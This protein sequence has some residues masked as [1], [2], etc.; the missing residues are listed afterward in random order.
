MFESFIIT[1]RESLEA[2]LIIGIV[3]AFLKNNKK[4]SLYKLIL[5]S[6]AAA[7]GASLLFAYLFSL[8]EGGFSGLNEELFEGITML[9]AGSLLTYMIVWLYKQKNYG[10]ELKSKLSQHVQNVQNTSLFFLV[11]FA[12]LREGVETVLF[13]NAITYSSGQIA[14]TGGFIGLFAA[15]I[16]GY[17]LFV[18]EVKLPIKK[19]FQFTS[20]LLIL[21]A[22]GLF[23]HGIHELQEAGIVPIITEHLYDIN[24]I[25]NEKST[26]GEFAKGIFGYNGNPSLIE[27]VTYVLYASGAFYLFSRGTKFKKSNK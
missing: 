17:A 6:I 18:L 27:T 24:H 15:I 26:L 19:F 11:F 25:F 9:I 22:A 21:F 23:A 7:I 3:F 2:A 4:E 12:I 10:K 8:V 14:L 5:L 13:L 20:F 16:I 1:F